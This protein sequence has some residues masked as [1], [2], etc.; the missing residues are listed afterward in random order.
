MAR[1]GASCLDAV[2]HL[3]AFRDK[4]LTRSAV[5]SRNQTALSCSM[6]PL[7][8]VVIDLEKLRHVN[9]GLGRYALYFAKAIIEVAEGRFEPVFFLPHGAEA[10]F[11]E[12]GFE[13]KR[14]A[15][16]RKETVVRLV[17]PVV[18]RM[19]P[20]PKDGLWHVTNQHSKYM[21]LDPRVPVILTIHDLN[22]LHDTSSLTS[23]HKTARKLRA[24]QKKIDRAAAVTAISQFV[25]D[26]VEKTLKLHNKPISVI[27]NG[28][29]PAPKASVVRPPFAPMGSFLFTV[30]NFL[31]HKNFHVLL[32]FME[33]MPDHVL[34]MA[35]KKATHYGQFVERER[36]RRGLTDRV[37]MPGEVSDGD[38]QWLYENCEAFLFPSLA[39]GFGFPVLEAMQCGK[40]VFAARTTSLPEIVSNKGF[41]FDSFEPGEMVNVFRAGMTS[42]SSDPG[43]ASESQ[44]WATNFSWRKAAE[45]YAAVYDRVLGDGNSRG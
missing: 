24:M 3:L 23:E 31:K 43:R 37:I 9:A 4:L 39:E 7:P 30:G 6:N 42:W 33:A 41:F 26:D 13:V 16:W 14:V 34:V 18:S 25:A 27:Y 8:R 15:P 29:A 20:E 19:L 21:P 12:G 17:R 32:D 5:P 36:E 11:P 38:R 45:E 1:P 22:F 40:P 44:T 10:L 28:M 35:G 2:T